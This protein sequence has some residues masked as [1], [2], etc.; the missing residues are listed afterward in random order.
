MIQSLFLQYLLMPLLALLL[1]GLM[2][3][4]KKKNPL[5][6]NKHLIIFILLNALLVGLPGLFGIV[7]NNFNPW[8]Y[9]IAQLVYVFIGIGFMQGYNKYFH[10]Q[11]KIHKI[12]FQ[13]LVLLV[14]MTLGGYLFA[15]AFNWLSNINN[16][17]SAASCILVLP[18]PLIFYWT[19]IAFIDIPFEIYNV[20]QYP[21][22]SAEISFDGMDFNKLMVLEL[23]FGKQPDDVD[24][25]K[26]K[27]KAPADMPLGEWFKK[28]IDDYNYKFPNQSI[29][30]T[31]KKGEPHGW[32][33]YVKKSFFH[34]KRLLDPELSVEKNKI[35]EHVTII[36]KRVIEHK[37][38]RVSNQPKPKLILEV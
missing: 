14:I 6:N 34:K 25:I 15:L 13:I 9:L 20:W 22:G 10:E 36:S 30:Y 4:V 23:E 37:E 21:I 24:R 35:Q 5:I 28:F 31:D 2:A 27:A 33:F 3:S 8:Y 16:G 26:V 7:G 18:I 29:A 19:Y 32:I 11:V 1:T 12:S 38:E 17:Y